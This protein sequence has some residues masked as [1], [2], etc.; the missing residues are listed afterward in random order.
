[1]STSTPEIITP[2]QTRGLKR[3][4]IANVVI[5]ALWV[6]LV[7]LI[8]THLTTAPLEHDESFTLSIA[9]L[10]WHQAWAAAVADAS[11][12]PIYTMLVKLWI[13][14]GGT[15]LVWFR[16]LPAIIMSLL[17][18]PFLLL[19]RELRAPTIAS[20]LGLLL[21]LANPTR[22]YYAHNARSY[23][24]FMLLSAFSIWLFAR[25]TR[26]EDTSRRLW[27][28]YWFVNIAL[29]STHYFGLWVICIQGLIALF[30]CRKQ[31][32]HYV[33]GVVLIAFT[34]LL[35]IPAARHSTRHPGGLAGYIGWMPLP[36]FKDL[37]WY[38]HHLIGGLNIR[39]A[40][41]V[42]FLLFLLPLLLWSATSIVQWHR[43]SD[44]RRRALIHLL[45][46]ATLPVIGTFFL[47]HV[48][49]TPLFAERVLIFTVVPFCLAL[50]IALV[51][52]P[53]R[54]LRVSLYGALLAW[55]ASAGVM[56]ISSLSNNGVRWD[57]LA[58]CVGR[59]RGASI[60]VYAKEDWLALP[61]VMSQ[62]MAGKD[63]DVRIVERF[64]SG[65]P[66]EFWAAYR[67]FSEKPQYTA[68]IESELRTADYKSIRTCEVGDGNTDRHVIF[69]LESREAH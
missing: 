53:Y 2:A 35:W 60:P 15:S 64:D 34:Y 37:A 22:I 12:P 68:G 58:Q 13:G 14:L 63:P 41:E 10:P 46:Y 40:V 23:G 8:F 21:L 5:A 17:P 4:G 45:P 49:K 61:Y 47:S 1:M 44:A 51:S 36:T 65:S 6:V 32:L 18:V 38:Y 27:I 55:T 69:D 29:C 62:R 57:I 11:H 59:D 43:A 39:H 20:V 54:A 66:R 52:I 19:A 42:G 50:S 3:N 7:C 56:A 67:V 48:A 28:G 33:I 16:I 24:L 30:C 25:L 9:L 26:H 31:L